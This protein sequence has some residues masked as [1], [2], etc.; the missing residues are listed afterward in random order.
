LSRMATA[1]FAYEIAPDLRRPGQSSA[2]PRRDRDPSKPRHARMLALLPID[3]NLAEL[4]GFCV[5]VS[6]LGLQAQPGARKRP[7]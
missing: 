1:G 6:G 3:A 2:A 5:T 4:V 7:V